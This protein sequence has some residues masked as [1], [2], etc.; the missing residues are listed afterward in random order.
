MPLVTQ[1]RRVLVLTAFL[2]VASGAL[3]LAADEPARPVQETVISGLAHP[4]DMVFL[5][6]T[7]ALVTEKDGGLQRVDLKAGTFQE[8]SGFPDDLD[9][10]RRDDPRDN[11]GLFGIELDPDF[12]STGLI[13]VA[14]SAG[15]AKGTVLRVI[16]ARLSDNNTLTDIEQI[17][18]VEPPSTDRF[19]YGGGLVIGAD[20]KLYV[21]AG[22]R[23]FNEI[24]QPALPVAQDPSDARGKIYRL[25]PDGSIPKENPGFGSDAVPG[26]YALGI[27]A[28]QGITVH[29]QTGEIWFSEHGPRQG[30]EINRL[31]GG[32][33]NYGWPLVTTG[34]YRNDGFSPPEP[35]DRVLTEPAWSWDITVAPTGLVIYEGSEFPAWRGD[36]LVG[37]LSSGSFWR[38]DLEGHGIVGATRYF[39]ENPTRIRNVTQSPAGAVYILTDEPEGRIIRLR[40]EE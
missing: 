31:E 24:D 12:R 7:D 40:P 10:I 22:E 25:N 11:S 37:G 30:D 38:L 14:Y 35:G 16:R 6:E 26:L 34:T 9:N 18:K 27:R 2:G 32:G 13:Y 36:I 39:E 15:D 21:T 20:G 23:F 28:A 1:A 5:S 4:W 19:H 17:L 3:A 29:P 33:A 8:V